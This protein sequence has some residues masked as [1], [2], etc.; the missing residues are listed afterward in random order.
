MV[1]TEFNAEAQR[2]QRFAEEDTVFLSAF[3]RVLCVSALKSAPQI[4]N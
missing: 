3:L 1:T 4:P 2:P